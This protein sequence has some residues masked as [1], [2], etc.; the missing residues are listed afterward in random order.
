MEHE[1]AAGGNLFF[2]HLSAFSHYNNV[3]SP[4]S[5]NPL[6]QPSERHHTVVPHRTVAVNEQYVQ[7]G[8][9]MAVLESII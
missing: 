9:Y 5:R 8:F 2:S 3:G 6:S 1:H 7:P 4:Y